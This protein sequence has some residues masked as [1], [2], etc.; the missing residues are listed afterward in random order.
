[1]R[2][3]LVAFVP[4]LLAALFGHAQTKIFKEVSDEIRSQVQPILQDR[5]VVGYL[6]LTQLEKASQDSFNYRI[7]IMDENLNDIGKVEFKERNLDL[8]AVS[9]E[10]DVICLGYFRSI[11]GTKYKS[12]K[13]F[14]AA[15]RLAI[16]DVFLQ[17]LTLEGKILGSSS[18]RSE[19]ETESAYGYSNLASVSLRRPVQLANVSQKGFMCYYGDEANGKIA[20]YDSK[21]VQVWRKETAGQNLGDYVLSSGDDVFVL[22]QKKGMGEGGW[23]VKGYNFANGAEY[24]KLELKDK[25]GNKLHVTGW[26]NHPA[27]N[28]PYVSGLIINPKR[29]GVNTMKDLTKGPY[30]GVFTMDL[31][32]HTR[33]EIKETY[34]YWNDGSQPGISTK[35][36]IEQGKLYPNFDHSFKDLNGNTVF[37]GSS[38]QKKPRWGMIA[39]GVVLSPLI[40]VTPYMWALSGITKSHV[41][42]NALMLQTAKGE[43][44]LQEA[45]PSN[46]DR[47]AFNREPAAYTT[48]H[49]ITNADRKSEYLVMDE[50]KDV[51]IYSLNKKKVVRTIPHKDGNVHT[52]IMPAKDG[53]IMVVEYNRKERYT[54]VSIEQI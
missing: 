35:G 33:K 50:K 27:S 28:K 37:V 44:Q 32:G 38:I 54:K 21:G 18:L 41:T 46:S 42:D 25:Q 30:Y 11:S 5:S 39:T 19:V 53:H 4:F 23:E 24:D 13:E 36:R 34:S 45:I 17:F 29:D 49:R 43:L 26:G 9:F 1:M 8:Q 2:K 22:S 15:K 3:S 51:V 48:V 52:G 6:A 20:A 31:D 12:K 14:E 47:N 40:I 10:Q 16:N 7:S